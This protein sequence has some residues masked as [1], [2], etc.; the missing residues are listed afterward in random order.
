MSERTKTRVVFTDEQLDA[1][2]EKIGDHK[3]HEA[4][5]MMIAGMF[6]QMGVD[7]TDPTGPQI[8]PSDYE[9]PF[10]QADMLLQEI[11]ATKGDT[12]GV[13]TLGPWLGYGPSTFH[14]PPSEQ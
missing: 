3:G 12:P 9:V 10:D 8:N 5:V 13:M 2:R 7:L 1:I 14:R 6:Q 4:T 11:L